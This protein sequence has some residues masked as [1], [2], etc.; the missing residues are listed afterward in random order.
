M[1][2]ATKRML[3]LGVLAAAGYAV[4]RAFDARRVTSGVTWDPQPFPY[5]PVPRE[6]STEATS[7]IEPDA[8]TC[9]ASHPVK[10]KLSSGIFHVPGGA[11]YERTLADRCYSTAE[12]A[13]ADGLRAAK[14]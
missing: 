4:W 1:R 7:W 9:P 13:E 11:N 10:A 2:K 3:G 14:V 5:P 6:A 12:A 8:G